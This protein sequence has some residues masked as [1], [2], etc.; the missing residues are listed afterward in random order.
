MPTTNSYNAALELLQ[1]TNPQ[2]VERIRKL[3]KLERGWDGYGGDPPTE[4]AIKT[5]ATLLSDTSK[6]THGLLKIPFIAPSPDGGLALEW[7]L[8]SGAELML[9]IPPTDTD[10]RY[11]LDEPTN[12]G[13]IKKSEGALPQDATLTELIRRLTLKC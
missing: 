10:I 3:A 1:T 8:D 13:N 5:T 7:E 12:T 9:V 6:L 11:L 4:E 2:A